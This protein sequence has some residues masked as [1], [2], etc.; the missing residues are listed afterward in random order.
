MQAEGAVGHRAAGGTAVQGAIYRGRGPGLG[1]E[2]PATLS[3]EGCLRLAPSGV[4]RAKE[5]HP[6]ALCTA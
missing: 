3:T 1:T 2:A 4:G 5:E 6:S